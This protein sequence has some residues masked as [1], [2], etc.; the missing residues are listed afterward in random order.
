MKKE[1][2]KRREKEKKK[3]EKRGEK[4]RREKREERREKREERRENQE[5]SSIG[6]LCLKILSKDSDLIVITGKHRW[7]IIRGALIGNK[8]SILK[9]GEKFK[10]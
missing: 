3:R 1:K 6:S 7:A 10:L 9:R 2:G 4:E 5:N 8:R